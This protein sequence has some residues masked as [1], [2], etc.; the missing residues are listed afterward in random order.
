MKSLRAKMLFWSIGSILL[1]MV[2][3]GIFNHNQL[4]REL[5]ANLEQQRQGVMSRANAVLP[6]AIAN[7]ELRQITHYLDAEMNN[8]TVETLAVFDTGGAII[9]ARSRDAAGKSVSVET[10]PASFKAES[11]EEIIDVQLNGSQSLGRVEL[12]MSHRYMDETL[13]TGI[14]LLIRKILVVGFTL[15]FVIGLLVQRLAARPL[16]S[17]VDT[18]SEMAESNDGTLRAKKISDDEIGVVVDSVNRFLDVMADKIKQLERIADADLT[19]DLPLIS[20]R[21]TM[22]R[23]L[24]SLKEKMTHLVGEIKLTAQQVH[25][26]SQQLTE[27][28]NVL[29]EGASTQ[30]ASAEEASTSTEEMV[31]NIGQNAEY[32]A[33]TAEIALQSSQQAQ[34]GGQAVEATVAAMKEIAGKIQIVEE[35]ARQ[36]NLLALNAAIEAAR[37]GEHGKGFAVVAAEVRKLAERSQGAAGEISGLSVSSVEIAEKAG[38]LLAVIVPDIKK[39]SGLVEEI[40]AASKEQDTGAEHIR[41]AIQELDRVIQQNSAATEEMASTAEQLTAQADHLRQTIS[42]FKIDEKQSRAEISNYLLPPS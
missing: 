19:V 16:R 30:A 21:D 24:Q 31:A 26:G 18:M 33:Q 40:S 27:T 17:L 7:S 9:L 6:V 4:Q 34:E 35:I 12:T 1:L 8:P 11:S 23:S 36:T 2:S 29:N 15:M 10:L 42:T 39:T 14:D 3:M 25:L 13:S 5:S 38:K 41:L 28:S 20:E 32:A 22:G 37:A